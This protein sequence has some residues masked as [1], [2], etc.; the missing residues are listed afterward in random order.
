MLEGSILAAVVI[1]VAGAGAG[2]GVTPAYIDP[3][4]GSLILQ[5]AA[6]GLVGAALMIRR[7]RD[8][9]TGGLRHAVNRVSGK[10]RREDNRS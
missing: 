8:G 4:S 1:H 9:I 10:V 5:A 6:A 3:G 7:F 2:S